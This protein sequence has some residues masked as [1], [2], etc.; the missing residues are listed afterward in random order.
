MYTDKPKPSEHFV[1]RA[2]FKVWDILAEGLAQ[3]KRAGVKTKVIWTR[4]KVI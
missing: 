2:R 4:A 1:T 3:K